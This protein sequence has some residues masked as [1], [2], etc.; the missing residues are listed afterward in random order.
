MHVY[1]VQHGEAKPAE[2]DPERHLTEKGLR[3]VRKVAE[4]LRPLRLPVEALWHSDKPRATAVISLSC[5]WRVY[6]R[7]EARL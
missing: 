3:D 2:E 7:C 5:F 4:F 1:L 6:S